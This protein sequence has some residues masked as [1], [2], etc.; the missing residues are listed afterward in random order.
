MSCEENTR[1][2]DAVAR[3]LGVRWCSGCNAD[4][5]AAGF[6]KKGCR[7]ICAGCQLRRK[8]REPGTWI[9]KAVRR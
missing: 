2:N 1:V 4:K 6:I 9:P 5:P 8:T 7:W 3:N